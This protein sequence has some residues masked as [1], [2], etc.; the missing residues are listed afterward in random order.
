MPVR[1]WTVNRP[2]GLVQRDEALWTIDDEVPG[3][4]NAGR[5]MTLVKR[6]DGAL[7]FFNAIPV[8]DSTLAQIRALGRPAQL[9]IP[10][11]YHSLDAAAFVEKLGVVAYAPVIDVAKV[12][13]RVACQPMTSLPLDAS[14]KWFAVEGFSTHETVL[15]SRTTLI[16]A[17]LVTNVAHTFNIPGLMMR[18]IG[19]T[20]PQPI[21]PGPVRKRV[22]RN[23]PAVKALLE[24]LAAIK[25]LSR[26]VPT[27]G[28]VF[29]GDAP[30]A[31][32]AIANSL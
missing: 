27:H 32:R 8:P 31:L 14:L 13:E 23:F 21:L 15:L 29:E 18:L 12:S 22:G 7:L 5:R 10:N 3:L 11:R 20:G 30:A 4:P 25:G 2:Q 16:I 26:I 19:F 9:I 24:Q 28:A 6:P 1:P 17:D